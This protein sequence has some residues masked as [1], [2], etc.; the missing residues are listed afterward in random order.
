MLCGS[1]LKKSED[2]VSQLEKEIGENEKLM[3]ELTEQ[4]KKLEEQA[5]EIMQTYQQ[6]EVLPSL[7]TLSQTVK[8]CSFLSLCVCVGSSAGGSGAASWSPAGDQGPTGA[9]ARAAEGVSKCAAEG[10]A[11]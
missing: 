4:L 5:G 6:A 10:G 1:N 2:S 3:E 9:R 8:M 11:H 7:S